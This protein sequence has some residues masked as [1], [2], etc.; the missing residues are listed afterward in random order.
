MTSLYRIL[1]R[2][3]IIIL[4][5]IIFLYNIIVKKELL[6]SNHL[7]LPGLHLNL[8][9]LENVAI[10]RKKFSIQRKRLNS[11][12]SL[13]TFLEFCQAFLRRE[14]PV[15]VSLFLVASGFYNFM[16]LKRITDLAW[17]QKVKIH[18]ESQFFE[19]VRERDFQLRRLEFLQIETL[20]K[21]FPFW[22]YIWMIIFPVV[23]NVCATH[24]WTDRRL[25]LNRLAETYGRSYSECLR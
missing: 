12:R 1:L 9:N 16:T 4:Y 6:R 22:S 14:I 25:I 19:T 17:S 24:I 23:G 2:I 15:S 10:W 8:L 13:A 20:R 3:Y 21:V 7:F 5:Y 11:R 18:G